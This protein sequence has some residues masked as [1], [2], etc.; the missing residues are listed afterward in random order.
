MTRVFFLEG[1]STGPCLILTSSASGSIFVPNS[2]TGTLFTK[3]LPLSM[4]SSAC[5]REQYPVWAMY[6]LRRMLLDDSSIGFLQNVLKS[7][8][9]LEAK[10]PWCRLGFQGDK[11]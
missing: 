9:F 4:S 6:L 1:L 5:R 11:L 10:L 7:E 3:T 8:R 2:F